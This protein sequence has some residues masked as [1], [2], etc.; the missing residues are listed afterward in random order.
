MEAGLG[1]AQGA[2][3][4]PVD[5]LPRGPSAQLRAHLPLR[6]A[7]PITLT[8]HKAAWAFHVLRAALNQQGTGAMDQAPS[9]A[10]RF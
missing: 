6:Q 7:G 2:V 4:D 9:P 3:A 10:G 5:S 1:V 8:G